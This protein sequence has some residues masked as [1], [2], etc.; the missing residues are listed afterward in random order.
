M[1]EKAGFVGFN[2]S[3]WRP[4]SYRNQSID[5]QSKSMDWFLYGNDLRL[6]R[7]K[8]AVL[9]KVTQ[10]KMCYSLGNVILLIKT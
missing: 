9:S 1:N 7:V 10:T 6:E 4:L 3:R 5:L 8:N 2:L